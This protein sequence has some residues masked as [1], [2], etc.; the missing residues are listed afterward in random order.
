EMM[1][2]RTAVAVRPVRTASEQVDGLGH[3]LYEALI[4]ASALVLRRKRHLFAVFD[5]LDWGIPQIAQDVIRLKARLLY[6]FFQAPSR[7]PDDMF[8]E[9][10]TRVPRD[11]L[12]SDA[13]LV[14]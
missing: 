5:G 14:I 2:K 8:A 7:F 9:D 12:W 1:A 11:Q 4:L 3:L 13:E 10:F 6:D